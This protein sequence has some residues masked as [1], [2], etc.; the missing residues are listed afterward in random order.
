MTG[1]V[2][3]GLVGIPRIAYHSRCALVIYS[4]R[5]P[6]QTVEYR[7]SHRKAIEYPLCVAQKR[8]KIKVFV[9][10]HSNGYT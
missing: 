1:P 5:N 3:N 7:S 6:S 2:F 4:R 10:Y 9:G 8:E